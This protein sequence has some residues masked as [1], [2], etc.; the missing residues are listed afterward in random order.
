MTTAASIHVATPSEREIL[1]TRLFDAPRALV[2]ECYTKA[3][4]LK[5][6]MQ[7]DGWTFVHCDNNLSIGG[8]FH[9]RWRNAQRHEM[10]IHGVYRE[11]VPLRRIVRTEIFDLDPTQSESLGTLSLEED[12]RKTTLTIRVLYPSQQARDQALKS[13]ADKGVVTAKLDTLLDELKRTQVNA[14]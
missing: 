11:I 7:P 13:C 10:G 4:L 14:A 8:A 1:M 2:Y 6:W 3:A 12:N 5:R 9:W